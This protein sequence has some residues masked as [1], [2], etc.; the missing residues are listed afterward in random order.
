[1]LRSV[2]DLEKCSI[3]ATDGAIGRVEDFYFDD[4]QWVVRYLVV[5]TGNWFFDRRVLISPLSIRQT[6]WA[7]G[8]VPASITLEQVK[9]SPSVDTDEP[10]SRQYE[11][12][13]YGYYGYPYY[14]GGMGLWGAQP[15][16]SMM[17]PSLSHT[18]GEAE[19]ASDQR[20]KEDAHLRSCNAVDGYHVH[21]ADGEIGHVCGYLIDEKSWAIRFL[22]VNTSN[23][24]MGHQVL[25]ASEWIASVDWAL[26]TVT[27]ALTRQAIKEAP[28]FD[29]EL[30]LDASGEQSLYSHYG[31]PVYREDAVRA[32][33]ANA[34]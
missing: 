34:S 17:M 2:K 16:P 11:E 27:T 25:V 9:N 10:V 13:Y 3:E 6:G 33:V 22:V 29:P 30:L 23:W 21:A 15:Y 7:S 4:E 5:R 20:E 14:W 24:W 32:R 8:I 28:T 12:S 31:R 19:I 18:S 1:M 26:S